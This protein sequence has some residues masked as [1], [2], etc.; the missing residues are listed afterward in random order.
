LASAERTKGWRSA[1]RPVVKRER[2]RQMP[3]L[4]S[5]TPSSKVKSQPTDISMVTFL[6]IS[7]SPPLRHSLFAAPH[8]FSLLSPGV[9]TGKTFTAIALALPGST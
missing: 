2:L 6:P 8:C 7:P 5:R 3:V 9:S 1:A 4:R